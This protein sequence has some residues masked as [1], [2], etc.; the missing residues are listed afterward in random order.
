MW[1]QVAWFGQGGPTLPEMPHALS[2]GA[3]VVLQVK[4][5][6]MVPT[7][8]GRLRTRSAL[9]AAWLQRCKLGSERQQPKSASQDGRLTDR[10]ATLHLHAYIGFVG[11][12]ELD[13]LSSPALIGAL[14]SCSHDCWS[15]NLG[16]CQLA[17]RARSDKELEQ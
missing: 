5:V 10:P 16:V 1:S 15:S 9:Q 12:L 6:L 8:A 17:T 11:I 7:R 13:Q 4:G 2:S 14:A 3:F